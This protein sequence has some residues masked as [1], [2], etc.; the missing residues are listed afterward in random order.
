MGYKVNSPIFSCSIGFWFYLNVVGYKEEEFQ[1][2]R[3]EY[4]E[5]FI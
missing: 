3:K 1:M 5:G 4:E 2:K